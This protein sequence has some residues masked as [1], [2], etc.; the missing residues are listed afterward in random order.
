MYLRVAGMFVVFGLRLCLLVMA[1]EAHQ[2]YSHSG[3]HPAIQYI[4]GQLAIG[5]CTPDQPVS[6]QAAHEQRTPTVTLHRRTAVSAEP[7]NILSEPV[8]YPTTAADSGSFVWILGSRAPP[9]GIPG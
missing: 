7:R 1:A 9:P 3:R 2:L 6:V 8:Y 4:D 5:R